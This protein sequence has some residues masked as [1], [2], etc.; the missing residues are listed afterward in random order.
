MVKYTIGFCLKVRTE[1]GPEDVGAA[2]GIQTARV[3]SM[4]S[5]AAVVARGWGQCCVSGCSDIRVDDDSK[6]RSLL[7]YPNQPCHF[8]FLFSL[9]IKPEYC[10]YLIGC[11]DWWDVIKE[12]EWISLD[13][14]TGEVIILGEQPLPST[15]LSN[16]L[17]TFMSLDGRN[18]SA[19]GAR[20]VTRSKNSNCVTFL[21][22]HIFECD[23]GAGYGKCWYPWWCSHGKGKWSLGY[24]IM[25]SRAHVW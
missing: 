22:P 5:H 19:Q 18:C 13:G 3:G 11:W 2:A 8:V 16:E 21:Y 14:S 24:W 9:S 17:E 12:G 1:T 25:Q 6:V 10:R 7:S 23:A 15:A 4:T 20:F